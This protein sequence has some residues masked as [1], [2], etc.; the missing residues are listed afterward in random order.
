MV[1]IAGIA[2]VANVIL[3][4]F[5][6][7]FDYLEKIFSVYFAVPIFVVCWLV[8]PLLKRFIPFSR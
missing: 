2:S 3:M 5:I 1:L 6:S 7:K 4:Q 8:A